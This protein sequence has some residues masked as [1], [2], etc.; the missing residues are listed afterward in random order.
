MAVIVGG[1]PLGE[2]R[3]KMGGLIFSRNKGGQY[4]KAYAMPID[5]ASS[6]QINAR[7]AFAQAI[8]AFHTMNPTDKAG[9][10]AFA[11]A[12]FSSKNRGNVPGLHSGVNAF[13]G[14][15]NISINMLR[16]QTDLADLV[17]EINGTPATLPAQGTPVI[18][19]IAPILP[20]QG[21]LDN[22]N[23]SIVGVTDMSFD[24]GTGVSTFTFQTAWNSSPSAPTP[25][26]STG[27]IFSD[28]EGQ[29]VGFAVY[30]S[31]LLA[32]AGTFVNNPDLI[33]LG[34]TG[35]ITSYTTPS[36]ITNEVKVDLI[37]TAD[38]T[39]YMNALVSSG[40]YRL[41]LYMYNTFGQI[42][43]IG[44]FTTDAA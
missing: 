25:T 14:L 32:Q 39:G 7:T 3:G 5:P 23:Y 20:L 28:G 15:R 44:E 42:I 37:G 36:V 22:G 13:V 29:S 30:A 41:Q 24:S 1:S 38:Y 4:V 21:V 2:L 12:Y 35:I 26:A 18:S 9:W 27:S 11:S 33:L 16:M 6:A 17:I 19:N 40:T 8:S 10:Q 43:K 31:N 34:S